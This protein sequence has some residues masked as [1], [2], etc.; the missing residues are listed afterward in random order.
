MAYLIQVSFSRYNKKIEHLENTKLKND[1]SE[2]TPSVAEFLRKK[3]NC[4]SYYVYATTEYN[5]MPEND[6]VY[7]FDTQNQ[8]Y[9]AV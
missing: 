9:R 6:V 3:L 4:K 5:S 1:D 7:L 8:L 2:D